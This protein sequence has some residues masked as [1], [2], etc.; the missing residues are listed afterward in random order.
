MSHRTE[1]GPFLYLDKCMSCSEYEWVCGVNLEGTSDPQHGD[2]CHSQPQQAPIALVKPVCLQQLFLV[3]LL[4]NLHSVQMLIV[5][6]STK[7][8][9]PWVL[10]PGGH[11][12]G[13]RTCCCTISVR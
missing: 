1:G 12:R 11:S 3:L 9:R 6:S 10:A 13:S 5:T 8:C 2:G 4:G 7:A